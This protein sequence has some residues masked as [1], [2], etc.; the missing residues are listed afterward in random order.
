MAIDLCTASSDES[1][2]DGDL[3]IPVD[4]GNLRAGRISL[5]IDEEW[6]AVCDFAWGIEEARVVC[7]QLGFPVEGSRMLRCS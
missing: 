4:R 7:K 3:R 6:R 5:C 2:T 1:C